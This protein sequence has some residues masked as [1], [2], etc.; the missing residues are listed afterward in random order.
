MDA[1]AASTRRPHPGFAGAAVALVVVV[2]AASAA[3]L[4]LG[5]TP[6]PGLTKV[7]GRGSSIAVSVPVERLVELSD[8]IVVGTVTKIEDRPGYE[9]YQISYRVETVLRGDDLTTVT[10]ADGLGRA[11]PFFSAA[12]DDRQI[13]F[14]SRKG[15]GVFAP[16]WLEQGVF[17]FTGPTAAINPR[18]R[19]VDL[20]QLEA[21]LSPAG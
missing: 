9:S 3:W 14:L 15:R 5:D 1:L 11:G 13:L 17:R 7:E 16:V 12:V 18:G 10:V 20:A 4:R 21:R 2:L 6:P 19:T 8:A